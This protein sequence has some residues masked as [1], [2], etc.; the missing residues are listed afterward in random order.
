MN[1]VFSTLSN[2]YNKLHNIQKNPSCEKNY[3]TNP[4]KEPDTKE[5]YTAKTKK[6]LSELKYVAIGI[7]ILYFAMKRNIN[8][9]CLKRQE[10]KVEKAAKIRKP[11][12]KSHTAL[13]ELI[14]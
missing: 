11:T 8:K 10:A 6:I 5:I 3:N 2:Q 13:Q 4:Q 9:D 7:F 1:V 12:I 14:A